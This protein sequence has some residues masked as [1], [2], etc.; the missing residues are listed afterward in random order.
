MR[1]PPFSSAPSLIFICFLPFTP[2]GRPPTPRARLGGDAALLK[3]TSDVCFQGRRGDSHSRFAAFPD[4]AGW[5]ALC[6]RGGGCLS[7]L[8]HFLR[9]FDSGSSAELLLAAETEWKTQLLPLMNR[10]T[11]WREK[12]M[13]F[14]DSLP[15]SPW[16]YGESVGAVGAS[17]LSL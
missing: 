8:A 11:V 4:P 12:Q 10:L 15:G 13:A 7:E 14:P 2:G 6:R 17:P 9:L 3:R 1:S 5:S 16:M